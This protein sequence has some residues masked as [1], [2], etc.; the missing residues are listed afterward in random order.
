MLFCIAG[1]LLNELLD[2]GVLRH[3]LRAENA[4]ML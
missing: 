3:A 1:S 4:T 2:D